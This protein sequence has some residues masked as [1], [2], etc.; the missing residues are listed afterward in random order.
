MD[1]SCI[2]KAV[3]VIVNNVFDITCEGVLGLYISSAKYDYK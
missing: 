1:T 3:T 2:G